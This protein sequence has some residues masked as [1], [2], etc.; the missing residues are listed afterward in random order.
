MNRRINGRIESLSIN[1]ASVMHSLR[2]VRSYGVYELESIYDEAE[3]PV[4]N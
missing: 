4:L 3:V 1:D 2:T